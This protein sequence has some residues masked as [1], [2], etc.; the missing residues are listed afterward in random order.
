MALSTYQYRISMTTKSY[1]KSHLYSSKQLTPHKV[2]HSF[3]S[4]NKYFILI[5]SIKSLHLHIIWQDVLLLYPQEDPYCWCYGWLIN[6]KIWELSKYLC[7]CHVLAWWDY[8]NQ[9][10]HVSVFIRGNTKMHT[11]TNTHTRA[12]IRRR[13]VRETKREMFERQKDTHNSL[14]P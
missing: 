7:F 11:R 3:A 1:Q 6:G 2:N 4:I 12:N 14:I 13:T 8:F 10:L 9:Q 5:M